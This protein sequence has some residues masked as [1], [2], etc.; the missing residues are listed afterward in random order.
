MNYYLTL[1]ADHPDNELNDSPIGLPYLVE[2]YLIGKRFTDL[3]YSDNMIDIS[4]KVSKEVEASWIGAS[5][6]G[7]S[8]PAA[9]KPHEFVKGLKEAA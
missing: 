3:V 8:V 5:M 2:G 7:W 4:D 6:F 9:I 1:G